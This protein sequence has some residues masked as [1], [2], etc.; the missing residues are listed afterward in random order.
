MTQEEAYE[1]LKRE[2][3]QDFGYDVA[4]WKKHI[5]AHGGPTRYKRPPL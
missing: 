2:T 5:N 1:I 3:G 4:G